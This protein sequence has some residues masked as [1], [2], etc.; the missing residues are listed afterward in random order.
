MLLIAF[1]EGIRRIKVVN[2]LA[3]SF[4]AVLVY[5]PLVKL[6]GLI[7][8]RQKLCLF[9]MGVVI[10]LEQTVGLRLGGLGEGGVAGTFGGSPQ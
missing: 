5:V 4:L 9:T 1:S 3:L 10:S 7:H 2:P 6:N 8:R